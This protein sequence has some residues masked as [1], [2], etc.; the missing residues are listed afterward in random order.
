MAS[1]TKIL[2]VGCGSIGQRHARL[3]AER[4]DVTLALCDPDADHLAA[5][6]AATHASESH[7]DV[8]TALAQKP[9]VV[10][11]CTPNRLH[12]PVAIAAMKAGADVFCEKPIAHSVQAA[13]EMVDTSA[14][15]GRLIHVGYILRQHPMVRRMQEIVADRGIGRVV[16]GRAMVGTYFT[17]QC[18]RTPY[19]LEE[20]NALIFDYT[21]ELDLLGLFFGKP[22]CVVAARARLGDLEIK[23]DPNLFQAIVGF[24]SGAVASVH[25]D[26][27]QQPQRRSLE[28][29]GDRGHLLAD[30]TDNELRHYEHD[31]DG[32]HSYPFS[33]GRDDMF[34][35]QIEAFLRAVRVTREPPVSGEQALTAL[36][37]AEAAIQSAE[38]ASWVDVAGG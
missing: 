2:V 37:L 12:A 35:G 18:A 26:Y 27:I 14:R 33:M 3:L 5:A 11:V 1:K 25:M 21:H 6:R 24:R 32:Y 31:K 7:A 13:D 36:R 17:L 20:P 28:L 15:T 10:F 23:P 34:R 8:Q 19:R 9:D 16:S 38:R 22:R 30:F 29:Y 4:E